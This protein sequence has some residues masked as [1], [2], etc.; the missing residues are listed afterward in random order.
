MDNNIPDLGGVQCTRSI[1]L[2]KHLQHIPVIFC[3]GSDDGEK[4]AAQAGADAFLA[5]PFNM[6]KLNEIITKVSL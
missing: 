4:L 5:K 1:K 6:V 3:T 2:Q